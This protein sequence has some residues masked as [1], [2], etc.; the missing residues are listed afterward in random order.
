MECDSDA[1]VSLSNAIEK[2]SHATVM[3]SIAIENDSIAKE[4]DLDGSDG[5]TEPYSVTVGQPATTRTSSTRP[6]RIF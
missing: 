6:L 2:D 4:G 3:L 1:F 5:P